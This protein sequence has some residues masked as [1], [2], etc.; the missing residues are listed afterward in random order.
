MGES[1]RVITVL[2]VVT[3]GSCLR[4][5]TLHYNAYLPYGS[6][7]PYQHNNCYMV[8]SLA[9]LHTSLNRYLPDD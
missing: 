7:C 8:R 3:I 5:H 1:C 4:R 9:Y 2:P 6:R